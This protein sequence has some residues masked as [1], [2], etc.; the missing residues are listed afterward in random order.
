MDHKT[1]RAVLDEHQQG[2]VLKF[3]DKLDDAQQARLLGQIESLDFKA[4]ERIR[5]ILAGGTSA[6][7]AAAGP[8]TPA[9]VL[10][11]RAN[12]AEEPRRTGEAALAK[13]EVGVILVA[14]GQGTRLGYDGPKG[15]YALAPLSNASLFEI[16]ARKILALERRHDASIPLYIMTSQAN[17][18]DTRQFFK[19]HAFFG[20]TPDRVK[21]FTQGMLPAFW[22]DG[23]LVLEGPDRLF[24]APDGHGGVLS[25]LDRTGMLADMKRRGVT[26]L[27]FFQVDNP[28]VE[29]AEPVFIGLH[30]ARGS[31]MSVKV[32][33][34]RDAAEGLGV[35][36]LRDGRHAVV[37][38]TELT[39]QQKNARQPDGELLFKYGSVAIHIFSRTFLEREAAAG[40]PLHQAHKKVPF[41]DE[42]GTTRKPAAANAFKF[43]KF[44][45][46][47]LPDATRPL[48]LEFAREDEFSPVKNAE[49]ND[50]PAT[51]R[52]A[53]IEKAA[54]WLAACGV[55]MPRDAGGQPVYR[56]E[57]DPVYANSA[58][59]LKQRL[60]PG[61]EIGGDALLK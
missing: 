47:A 28:L 33:A 11:L 32:C 60:P 1:A 26:T 37:E 6:V 36:V 20:L 2:H 58:D 30:V 24:L 45:F 22:P 7:H 49:G 23:R 19:Q 18:A 13:G 10:A 3:W 41:C 14:G 48:I 42:T 27:F 40:L 61:F 51:A 5:S 39:D 29:I 54:R 15:T 52:L 25:A 50:S 44:I 4:L 56:L 21:F 57:I 8:M 17:D 59:E 16:H 43:E 9:P 31:E 38:Y 34:K 35:V 55:K 46:D 12:E 53:M